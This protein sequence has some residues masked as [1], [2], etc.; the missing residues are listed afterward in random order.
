MTQTE[1]ICPSSFYTWCSVSWIIINS[2]ISEEWFKNK[3]AHYCFCRYVH[4]KGCVATTG[5][6]TI[7]VSTSFLPELSS[8]HPPHFFFTYR[9]RYLSVCLC[10]ACYS[11]VV[12]NVCF[13]NRDVEQRVAWSCLSARQPLLENHHLWRQRGGSSGAGGGWYAARIT[14][15]HVQLHLDQLILPAECVSVCVCVGE[16]PVMRPGKVH[17]YASCTTF[18]TPSEYMEGHYTFRRL[19][20][21]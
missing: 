15:P 16:F 18:S 3:H 11:C 14:W 7:S 8:V 20:N 21:L 12:T 9:I 1:H 10:S 2:P 6:I 4:D 19:G 5:D 13:Q 17:E